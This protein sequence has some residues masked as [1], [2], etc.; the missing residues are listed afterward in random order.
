AGSIS[1][2][3]RDE[4]TSL[5][6]SGVQVSAWREASPIESLGSVDFTDAGGRYEISGLPEADYIIQFSP[7]GQNYVP[8]YYEN[9]DSNLDADPVHLGQ[10]ESRTIDVSL[11]VGGRITGQVVSAVGGIPLEGV[12]VC[13]GSP[14]DEQGGCSESGADG[15]YVVQGLPTNSY[16]VDFSPDWGL[17]YFA[18]WYGGTT[19]R[20]HATVVP[21]TAGMTASGINEGL[22]ES[23][24]VSGTL[25]DGATGEPVSRVEVCAI[26]IGGEEFP[27]CSETKADGH[28]LVGGMETGS[29]QLVF[30]PE[31]RRDMPESQEEEDGYFAQYYEG[32]TTRKDA[33]SIL[34]TAP[35]LRTGVDAVLIPKHP[36]PPAQAIGP[37]NPHG[38]PLGPPA[39]R[40]KTFLGRGRSKV[41]K[42]MATFWFH[43]SRT[44]VGFRCGLDGHRPVPCSSPVKFSGLSYGQHHLEVRADAAAGPVVPSRGLR[45]TFYIKPYR[46]SH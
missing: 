5:P 24:G 41:H 18:R 38:S 26:E 1:G 23:A 39:V 19:E 44:G 33:L 42:R 17:N 14:E 31:T 46:S 8:E 15:T 12:F 34:L 32:A 16:V 7:S 40:S 25:T 6:V 28:Y 10:G 4:S 22:L 20:R 35:G 29:Y 45:W 43:A 30:S 37:P 9:K 13:A 21:V 11:T 3:V 36:R 2:T 27:R